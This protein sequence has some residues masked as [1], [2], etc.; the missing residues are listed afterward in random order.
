MHYKKLCATVLAVSLL[1]GC[2]LFGD[3]DV[4]K[5]SPLPQVENQINV[6]K[7]WSTSIGDGAGKIY[8][9]LQP[10]YANG[11][12]YAADRDG[13]VKAINSASGKVVWKVNLSDK[14]GFFSSNQPAQLS[15]G[16][17]YSDNT[18]YVASEKA[19]L[20]ALNSSDGSLL[21][22]VTVSG[23]VLAQPAVGENTVLVNTSNGYLQALNAETGVTKW[24]INLG[25][26]L[27]A[28]RGDSTPV[29]AHGAAVVGSNTGR[30]SAVLLNQGQYIWQQ[31]I[32]KPGGSTEISRL[33]D[34]DAT[35]LIVEEIVYA[36][37]YNGYLVAIDLRTG[38]PIW[39]KDFGTVLDM[40][41]EN[42]KLFIVTNNDT[43]I[44]LN[45]ITSEVLWSQDKL[46]HRG[47]TA[48]VIY[49]E[50]LVIGDSE[51]YLHWLSKRDGHFVAQNKVSGSGLLAG[52]IVAGSQLMIQ[53]N[54][55]T[56][57]SFLQ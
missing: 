43:V 20:Y 33:S 52:P 15:G 50:Q 57:Y 16:V 53:A 36:T 41:A 40:V 5:M 24:T 18:L 51:G 39:Q 35:P 11:I 22:R 55:G 44:A 3:D 13:T 26:P 45:R 47:L 42:E 46:L 30:V 31:R 17:T 29:I 34:V 25:M 7:M 8:S 10:A 4:V 49:G 56:L 9:L 32:A 38:Q 37:A 23:E 14:T 28:L 6:Q 54:N 19:Q 2:S 1:S 21:W 27:L 12:V 48:P